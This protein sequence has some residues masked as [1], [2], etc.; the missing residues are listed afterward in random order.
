MDTGLDLMEI[1]RRAA[2]Y[3]VEGGA[4]ALA[5]HLVPQG[6]KLKLGEIVTIA[7]TA[8]AVFAVLDMYSPSIGA[9]SKTGAGLGI[10]LNLVGFPQ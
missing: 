3:L 5:A 8:A 9:S 1:L 4:V 7:V 6:H 2:K 10:G